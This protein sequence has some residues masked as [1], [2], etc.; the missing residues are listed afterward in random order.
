MANVAGLVR[1]AARWFGGDVAVVDGWRELT[2]R[3][4]DERSNRLAHALAELGQGPGSRVAMLLPNRAEWVE[5]DFAIAKAG[6]I[7][8][9]VNVRLSQS[10]REYI[11]AHSGAEVVFADEST[12]ASALAAREAV[13]TLR[14]VIDLGDAPGG[15]PAYED[16]LAAGSASAPQVRY[17]D[18]DGNFILYTSGTTGRPKGALSTNRGRIAATTSMLTDE[19]DVPRGGAMAHVASMAH[20]SGSKLLA[21]FVRGARNITVPKWDP[22][23][24]L[25]LVEDRRVSGSFLVPTMISMLV[26]AAREQRRDLSSLRTLSYGGAPIAPARL[27]EALDVLGDVLVQVYGS[28]EAP[29]PVFILTKGDHHPPPDRL[30]QLGSVGRE[31][32]HNQVRLVGEDGTSAPAGEPGEMWVRGPNVMAG[33]WNQP[34]ATASVLD[35]GWYRSGDI[36]WRDEYGYHYIV[37]RA[38]D[39]I[40]SGGLNVYPAEVERVIYEHPGIAEAA[41]IGIPDDTWGEAVHAVAVRRPGAEVTEDDIV[42]HCRTHLASYKKPRSVRFAEALPTGSTGKILKRELRDSYWN[43]RGR[44]V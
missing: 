15:L 42:E 37:D 22:D 14:H 30:G 7:R 10:E 12:V 17:G 32:L 6:M 40:I 26:D 16:V 34:E 18:D 35:D 11:L 43:T 19:L 23:A 27:G 29:H 33:Y 21:Y 9:P 8:V 13:E 39:M 5:I 25:Q 4:V 28:C 1:R 44:R 31:T 24:F 38:R 36:A 2:F 41:V 3:E 20:G